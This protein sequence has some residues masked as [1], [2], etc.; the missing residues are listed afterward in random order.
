MQAT[1]SDTN[2]GKKKKSG[3]TTFKMQGTIQMFF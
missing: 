2:S 3:S 1:W